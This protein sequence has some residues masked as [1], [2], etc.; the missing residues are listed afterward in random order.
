MC[1]IVRN[2]KKKLIEVQSENVQLRKE[3]LELEEALEH[4][5]QVERNLHKKISILEKNQ[6]PNKNNN[7]T[8]I[9]FVGKSNELSEFLKELISR[10]V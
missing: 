4:A 10:Q 1:E 7:A 3:N 9:R 6:R 8:C 5:F 2:L